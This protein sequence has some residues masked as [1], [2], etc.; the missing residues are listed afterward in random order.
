MFYIICYIFIYCNIDDILSKY[1][2]PYQ[3]INIDNEE[4]INANTEFYYAVTKINEIILWIYFGY[5]IITIFIAK[6]YFRRL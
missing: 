1:Y 6:M 3:S 2:L 4:F 5:V